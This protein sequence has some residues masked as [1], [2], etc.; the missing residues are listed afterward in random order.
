MKSDYI[1]RLKIYRNVVKNCIAESAEAVRH[2]SKDI[3]LYK[4]AIK[5]AKEYER[6][7]KFELTRV[8]REIE[9]LE[10]KKKS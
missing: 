8:T 6:H 5:T 1:T 2:A 7:H 10:K 4:A 9:K 3:E